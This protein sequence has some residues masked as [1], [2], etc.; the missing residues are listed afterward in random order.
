MHD[1]NFYIRSYFS[2]GAK[3]TA[4]YVKTRINH[5]AQKAAHTKMTSI[6]EPMGTRHFNDGHLS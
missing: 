6:Y 3:S 4:V 1:M 2:H 5:N